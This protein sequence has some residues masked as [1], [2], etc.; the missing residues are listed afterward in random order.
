M[1]DLWGFD[2]GIVRGGEV[3]AVENK[4]RRV[5][6]EFYK[7]SSRTGG[8][9]DS[10]FRWKIENGSTGGYMSDLRNFPDVAPGET[11]KRVYGEQRQF[12]GNYK[13][14]VG[15]EEALQMVIC[16]DLEYGLVP[17]PVAES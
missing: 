4:P 8:E 11:Q 1:R 2:I 13:T 6:L 17:G 15:K 3:G 9:E 16:V 12:P 14:A 7:M 5:R 10:N